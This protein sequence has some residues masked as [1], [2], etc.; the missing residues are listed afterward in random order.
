MSHPIIGKRRTFSTSYEPVD[1]IEHTASRAISQ[2][3]TDSNYA[4]PRNVSL[5]RRRFRHAV[6]DLWLLE[7][8]AWL[9]A[10]AATS[11]IVSVLIAFNRRPIP[12]WPYGITLG[13]LVSVLAT[14]A[15]IG[16]GEPVAAGLGQARWIWFSKERCMS[17][18]EL[19]DGA[20]RGPIG[21]GLM[22]FR[23]KGGSV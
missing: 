20:S 17:D 19:I 14:V 18:F 4:K 8:L 7:W 5:P 11:A 12:Y 22:I 9:V 23:G 21:S 3:D 10:L 2:F 6:V 16:L 1:S 13:A 15:T